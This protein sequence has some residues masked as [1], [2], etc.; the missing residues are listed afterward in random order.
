MGLFNKLF[1]PKEIQIAL[2]ILDE[3]S[4]EFN[5]EAFKLV[6]SRIEKAF[7]TNHHAFI[8]QIKKTGKTPRQQ[9]YLAIMN[10]A[11]NYL[12]SGQFHLHRGVLN[13]LGPANDL[14]HL[15][16]TAIDRLVQSGAEN[17]DIAQAAKTG[18]RENLKSVG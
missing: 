6:R 14:L 5:S 15:F 8:S 18:L 10:I 3:L 9:V 2:N 11:G 12:E 17:E 13:P 16:D 4:Y 7:L 1:V